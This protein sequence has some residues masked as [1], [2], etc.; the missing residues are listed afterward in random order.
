MVKDP[1]KNDFGSKSE[2]ERAA[3]GK[4]GHFAGEVWTFLRE[5][6]KWWMLPLIVVLVLVGGL[7]VLSSTAVA[8][9]IYTLF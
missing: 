8:P 9:F 3:A 4:P 6:R 7:I 2:F 1:L 5:N